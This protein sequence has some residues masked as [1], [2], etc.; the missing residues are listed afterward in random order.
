MPILSCPQTPTYRIIQTTVTDEDGIPYPTYGIEAVD[1]SGNVLRSI[2]DISLDLAAVT[3]L[4]H[5]M[6]T[7]RLALVHFLDVVEDFLDT[8]Q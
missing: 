5:K 4:A 2:P 7:H 3:A 1:Q 8:R 6:N